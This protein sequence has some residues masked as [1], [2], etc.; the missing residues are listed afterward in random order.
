MPGLFS[1]ED[2]FG[3]NDLE[4][5]SISPSITSSPKRALICT[6]DL[7]SLSEKIRADP[8]LEVD[9]HYPIEIDAT[10]NSPASIV[11][12]PSIFNS[13]KSVISSSVLN[14]STGSVISPSQ[15]ST[16]DSLG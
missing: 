12:A 10:Y 14:S 16:F 5:P 6:H 3:F 1:E 11:N 8:F 13:T 15:R 9:Q 7:V 2:P 4:V